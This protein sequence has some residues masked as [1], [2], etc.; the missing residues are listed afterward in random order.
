MLGAAAFLSILVASD[1]FLNFFCSH[2]PLAIYLA[3]GGL[4]A[5]AAGRFYRRFRL[6]TSGVTFIRRGAIALALF[7]AVGVVVL[8]ATPVDWDTKCSW[9]YCGRA[10]GPG[11]FKSPFPVGEPTCLGWS[12]CVNEYPYSRNEY[13]NVLERIKA[14]GCPAP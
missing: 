12:T 5:W 7:S 8:M 9:R 11:L 1:L 6:Q 14:Q 3:T 13:G 4:G 10:M 2:W